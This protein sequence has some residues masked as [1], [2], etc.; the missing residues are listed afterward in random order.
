[1]SDELIINVALTGCVAQKA[2]NP[3]LPTTPE[4]VAADARRCADLGATVFHV[5]AR[6]EMGAP[7]WGASQYAR[8]VAA[9]REA[10][11]GAIICCSTSGR[12]FSHFQE[13]SESIVAKPDLASL[14]VG[15]VDF[16]NRSV[17][18]SRWTVRG[19]LR[20]MD[21]WK[22]KPECELFDLGHAYHLRSLAEKGMVGVPAYCHLFA[23]VALPPR[24]LER[25]L[26]VLPERT[27]WGAAGV[28]EAQH[29]ATMW[30]VERGGHVRVGLEDNLWMGRHAP[31]TNPDL[32]RRIVDYAR[33]WGR[34]PATFE[35]TRE[36]L[37]L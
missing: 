33:A 2:D 5:H 15:S 4:E 6:T 7:T 20:I 25:L 24:E 35:R 3:A 23:G 36:I 29:H 8:Y 16:R 19:L 11:P 27:V 1:M 30:A 12:D 26:E 9:V 17:E 21:H 18:N 14:T 32:V 37:G 31:A 22:V 28:G 34:E 10:V 13:R